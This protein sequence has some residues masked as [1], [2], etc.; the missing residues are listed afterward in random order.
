M[1]TVEEKIGA[2]LRVPH[3]VSLATVTE[4]GDPWTRNVVALGDDS[5][6]IRIATHKEARKVQHILAQPRVHLCCGTNTLTE[7]APYMQVCGEA[8][9]DESVEAKAAFWNPGLT[10][11]FSGPEDPNYVLITVDVERVEYYA[12]ENP[13]VPEVWERE[14]S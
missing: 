10:N 1:K 7:I 13:M 12:P 8:F 11:Y 9:I 6:T 14:A 2:I 3:V 4:Q 5:M